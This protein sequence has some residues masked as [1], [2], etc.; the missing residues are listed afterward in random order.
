MVCIRQ[1]VYVSEIVLIYNMVF[2]KN[3]PLELLMNKTILE[4]IRILGNMVTGY[5]LTREHV[6]Q[7]MMLPS[8]SIPSLIIDSFSFVNSILFS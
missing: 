4:L 3:I 5:W 6:N 2:M 1:Q 8:L 7:Y